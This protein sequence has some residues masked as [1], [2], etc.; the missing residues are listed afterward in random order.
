MPF[1]LALT[2]YKLKTMSM[3]TSQ[4]KK[5]GKHRM[6]GTMQHLINNQNIVIYYFIYEVKKYKNLKT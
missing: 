3:H 2:R 6:A 5:K 4:K 1:A